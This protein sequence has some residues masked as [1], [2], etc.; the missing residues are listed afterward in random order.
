MSTT[1]VFPSTDEVRAAINTVPDPEMPPISVAELGMVVAVSVTPSDTGARV[2]IVLVPT[3]SGCP[4]TALIRTD[5]VAAV[6]RLDGVAGVN[7][8]FTNHVTWTADFITTQGRE[9]LREFGIAPP[10][11]GQTLVQLGG[12]RCP[13]C[14][15]RNTVPD[16]PFG[17]TPC[18]DTHFCNDCRNPFEALKA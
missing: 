14:A 18:R 4:A 11:S 17:P 3:F 6:Q 2:D 5:V 8:T 1:R 9:K 12:V 13:I 10:G 15:S 16:S 7:V